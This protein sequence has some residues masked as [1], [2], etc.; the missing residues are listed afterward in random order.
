MS[1]RGAWPSGRDAERGQASV[2]LVAMLPVAAVVMLTALQ[3]LAAGATHELAGHAAGAGAVALLES[4]DTEDAA[5]DAVPDWSR[6]AMRVTVKGSVVSVRLRPRT[7]VPGL[8]GKL[9]ST[10]RAD[11]G[12]GS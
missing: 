6:G 11:A 2:E 7:L 3:V 8:A 9:E 4:R 1:R 10:S 5:R 12:D